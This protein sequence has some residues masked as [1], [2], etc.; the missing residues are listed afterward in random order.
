[1]KPR[2]ESTGATKRRPDD[3][4]NPTAALVGAA[5]A[6]VA[7]VI[8]AVALWLLGTAFVPGLLAG[9][10]LSILAAMGYARL[11]SPV[12]ADLALAALAATTF[13]IVLLAIPLLVEAWALGRV[14]RD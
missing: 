4:G 3:G 14:L 1:V 6:A 9:G 13:Y 8:S 2:S 5:I 12:T 10:A 11:R 7:G